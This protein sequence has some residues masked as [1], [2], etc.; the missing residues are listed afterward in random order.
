MHFCRHLLKR[1]PALWTFA[2][3]EG[4][5]PTNNHAER[6]LRP[7]VTW[8]ETSFGCTSQGG[9]RFVERMLTAVQTCRLQG[10]PVLAHLV[11]ALTAHRHGCTDTNSRTSNGR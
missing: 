5:G 3:A 9:C 8:R 11:G 2:R 6:M 4:I 7:A 1:F 10:R